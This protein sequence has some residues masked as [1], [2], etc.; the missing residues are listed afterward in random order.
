MLHSTQP[1]RSEL[2]RLRAAVGRLSER[3]ADKAVSP[4]LRGGKVCP[5]LAST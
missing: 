3:I 2:K 5:R 4:E 1:A